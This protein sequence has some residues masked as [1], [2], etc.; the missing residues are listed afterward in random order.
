M[1]I[2][3]IIKELR[4]KRG[5]TQEEFSEA[6]QVSVQTVSRWENGVSHS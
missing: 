4:R 6:L 5:I 3:R 2:G 1:D